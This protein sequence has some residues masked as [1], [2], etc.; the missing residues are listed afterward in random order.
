MLHHTQPDIDLTAVWQGPNRLHYVISGWRVAEGTLGLRRAIQ[1]PDTRQ[2]AEVH[3]TEPVAVDEDALLRDYI[4]TAREPL[5]DPRITRLS[6]LILDLVSTYETAT[7]HPP[8]TAEEIRAALTAVEA[9][10]AEAAA[11]LRGAAA[12]A[13][14]AGFDRARHNARRR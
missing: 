11:R 9:I 3:P 1:D 2:W 12:A 13:S 4:P 8:T 14:R 6:T 7:G 10:P 5:A